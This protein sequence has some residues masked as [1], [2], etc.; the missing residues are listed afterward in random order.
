MTATRKN[1]FMGTVET[2]FPKTDVQLYIVQ[3]I[4][5]SLRFVSWKDRKAVV[6]D[7]KGIYQA[8]TK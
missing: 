8:G 7:L 3:M 1:A 6:T 4:R 5:G 2:V